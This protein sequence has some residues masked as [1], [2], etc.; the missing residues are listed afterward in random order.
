MTISEVIRRLQKDMEA[1]GDIDVLSY[2]IVDADSTREY[3][4]NGKDGNRQTLREFIKGVKE[5]RKLRDSN[6]QD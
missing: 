6:E 4:R 3:Y 1:L 2:K 5:A